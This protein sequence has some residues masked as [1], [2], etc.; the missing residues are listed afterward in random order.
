[1][2]TTDREFCIGDQLTFR[3]TIA[4]SSYEWRVT[5]FLGGS[6][7]NGG[8]TSGLNV[9]VG[10]FMLSASGIDSARMSTLQVTVFEGLIGE[11]TV[12]CRVPGI[13]TGGQSDTITVLGESFHHTY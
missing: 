5:G 2:T 8:I 1:M 13:S 3:C 4:A 10:E 6:M 12:T 7:G 11:R 9:T